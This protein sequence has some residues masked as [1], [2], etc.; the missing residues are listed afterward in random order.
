MFL[1]VGEQMLD[2]VDDQ[3]VRMAGAFMGGVGGTHEELCGVLSAGVMIT[4]ALLGPRY[5]GDDEDPMKQAITTYRERFIGEIGP[6]KCA[7]LR[8]GL[9]GSEGREPCSVL[10]RR[11]TRI[12]L[13]ILEE[14]A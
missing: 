6:T 13:E 9:Y 11:A 14:Y 10:A 12:L 2:H 7:A 1:A 4:G 3:M 8:D 5:P